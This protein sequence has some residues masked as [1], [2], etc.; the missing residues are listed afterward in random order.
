M[1]AQRRMELEAE[2]KMLALYRWWRNFHGHTLS[3]DIFKRVIP[4]FAGWDTVVKRVKY[5]MEVKSESL[6]SA[7]KV[8]FLKTLPKIND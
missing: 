7:C 4:P 8:V 3:V 6:E 1:A 2:Q 5:E